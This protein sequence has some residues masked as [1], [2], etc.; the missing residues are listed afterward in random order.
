MPFPTDT[1]FFNKAEMEHTSMVQEML[2][3]DPSKVARHGYYALMSG[4]TKVIPSM[5]NKLQSGMANM[6]PDEKIG[7]Y[8][9]KQKQPSDK[10]ARVGKWQHKRTTLF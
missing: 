2:M 6:L 4:D 5:K 3:G 7:E 10:K 8:I 1:D 9:N